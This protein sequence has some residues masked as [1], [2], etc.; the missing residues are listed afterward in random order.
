M[1]TINIHD[2]IMS[3]PAVKTKERSFNEKAEAPI[4]TRYMTE[5]EVEE[6]KHILVK[7]YPGFK[8]EDIFWK[9]HAIPEAD[10]DRE[11][12]IYLVYYMRT[13]KEG[14]KQD[15][16]IFKLKLPVPDTVKERYQRNREKEVRE[17]T[18]RKKR[19]NKQT[20]TITDGSVLGEDPN[21][22]TADQLLANQ[23]SNAQ[24]TP[25]VHEPPVTIPIR[26]VTKPPK[27]AAAKKQKRA[28]H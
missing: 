20:F 7:S 24:T 4:A 17:G 5:D 9:F 16:V 25:V 1:H 8:T 15:R 23:Y 6:Y 27:P 3:G 10:T 2:Y 12:F 19:P 21:V 28:L 22:Q 11:D 18:T 13:I 26:Q 14:K